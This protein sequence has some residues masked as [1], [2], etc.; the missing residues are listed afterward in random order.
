MKLH[1]LS[2]LIILL[3]FS[4]ASQAQFFYKMDDDFKFNGLNLARTDDNKTP[5]KNCTLI[6]HTDWGDIYKPAK[7]ELKTKGFTLQN[8]HYYTDLTDQPYV[9]LITAIATRGIV[10]EPIIRGDMAY[11]NEEEKNWDV[12]D[13]TW[14]SYRHS[15][16]YVFF[17][18]RPNSDTS[19]VLIVLRLV[20]GYA[21]DYLDY[22]DFVKL[23]GMD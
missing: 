11:G 5:L 7:D 13:R 3:C 8:I 2:M 23:L 16:T 22:Y 10:D 6:E 19:D 15:R 14:N 20:A 12:G 4:R 1:S 18:R 17:S 21:K 9:W